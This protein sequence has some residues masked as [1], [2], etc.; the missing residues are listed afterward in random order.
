MDR[1]CLLPTFLV[2]WLIGMALPVSASKINEGLQAFRSGD[3]RLAETHWLKLAESGNAKVQF[4]LSVMY[5]NGKG[6]LES[7][8]LS[9]IWLEKSADSG[10]APAQFNLGNHYFQGRW[11]TQDLSKARY[12]WQLSAEQGWEGAQFNL[13]N[14]YYRGVGV[15]INRG[16]ARYWLTLAASSG[17]EPA[18]NILKEMV[19]DDKNTRMLSEPSSSLV[20]VAIS[21]ESQQVSS[22]NP[23]KDRPQNTRSNLSDLE[24]GASWIKSRDGDNWT[25]QLLASEKL[26]QCIA[27]SQK[28]RQQLDKKL[29]AFRYQ[30]NQTIFCAVLV[31]DFD[32]REMAWSALSKLPKGITRGKPWAR[33][34]MSLQKRAL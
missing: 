15:K 24:V 21:S 3:E 8:R 9:L 13:G 29:V 25:L 12:L 23:L 16:Q 17:S 10:F 27:E 7:R 1:K 6:S 14:I 19:E 34:F 28:I 18:K 31:G 20:E 30:M 11:V 4:Y 2:V 33:K 26:E 5:G 32:T 22:K